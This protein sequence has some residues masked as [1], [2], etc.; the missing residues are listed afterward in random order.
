MDTLLSMR[1]FRRVVEAGSFI[2]AAEQ[3]GLSAAM[4]SRHVAHLERHLG[5]RLL[6]RSTRHLSLTDSG[7]SYFESCRSM[8]DELEDAESAV[9]QAAQAPRGHLRISA[10]VSFGVRH[11]GPAIADYMESYPEIVI[12]M[13]LDDRVVELAEEG[14]DLAVRVGHNPHPALIARKLCSVKMAMVCSPGYAERHGIPRTLDDLERHRAIGYAYSSYGDSWSFTG[15][16]GP[17]TVHFRPILRVNN[18]DFATAAAVSGVG[19]TSEPTFISGDELRAGRLIQV[20]ADHPQPELSLYAVY[21][22]RRFLSAKVRTFIDFLAERFG[23]MPYWDK[24]L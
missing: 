2:A 13:H 23:P 11:L 15:P 18:G 12:S 19:L 7:T 5:A 16:E 14:Y 6:N 4:A 8:L 9:S 21:L 1:V 3:L 10:P 17:R 22:S 20:L 24:D